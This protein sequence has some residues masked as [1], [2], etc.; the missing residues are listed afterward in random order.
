MRPNVSHCAPIPALLQTNRQ[1]RHEVLGLY[2]QHCA[3]DIIIHNNLKVA[4]VWIAD[5]PQGAGKFLLKNNNVNLRIVYD[6]FHPE[7]DRF[8]NF[9]SQMAGGPWQPHRKWYISAE[10]IAA[11]SE[12][13]EC[14]NDITTIRAE[15]GAQREADD[16]TTAAAPRRTGV[17][18]RRGRRR[19]K[20]ERS[21]GWLILSREL[22]TITKAM[23]EAL[24]ARSAGSKTG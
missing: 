19:S 4:Y 16:G 11:F 2:Y 21:K 5:L 17:V 7:Y 20:K 3:F 1:I 13:L 15:D 24:R 18:V 12:P 14:L 8:R 22:H 6:R 23:L 10:T 9:L